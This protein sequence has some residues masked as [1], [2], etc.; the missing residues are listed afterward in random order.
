MKTIFTI[1]AFI[2][3]L[4]MIGVPLVMGGKMIIREIK[5]IISTY[6]ILRKGKRLSYFIEEIIFIL[7]GQFLVAIAVVVALYPFI[8]LV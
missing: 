8:Q 6:P 1:A 5:D 3:W 4:G 2:L 7:F